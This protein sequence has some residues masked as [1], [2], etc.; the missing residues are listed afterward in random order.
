MVLEL[1]ISILDKIEDIN[2]NQLIF[3]S[4][5]LNE[6]QNNYQ[7]VSQLI[8]RVDEAEIQD[9]ID[10]GLI[11][12][13]VNADSKVYNKTD[14]LEKIL[15]EGQTMFDEFYDAFPP[16]VIRPD[17]LRGFL[18]TNRHKCRKLYNQ[19]IG[20]SRA[21]HLHIMACLS[22]EVRQKMATNNLGFMKTMWKWLANQEWEAIEEQMKD[23]QGTLLQQE[24]ETYGTTIL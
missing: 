23:E 6:G 7:S 19:I 2:L 4:L 5:V 1:D 18:R 13:E 12:V 15:D 21:K 17:G 20:R 11:S 22:T 10:K 3:L 16:V 9:L 8:S 14:K 24:V